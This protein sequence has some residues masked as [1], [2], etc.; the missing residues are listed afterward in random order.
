VLNY[1]ATAFEELVKP[2]SH[3]KV[4]LLLE[5]TDPAQCDQMD[6]YH[7]ILKGIGVGDGSGLM[8][9]LMDQGFLKFETGLSEE[10]KRVAGAVVDYFRQK[11]L[12][13]VIQAY[14]FVDSE[15]VEHSSDGTISAHD[16]MAEIG[17]SVQ[18]VTPAGNFMQ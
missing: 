15:L 1:Q 7:A 10:S 8:E 13:D 14:L 16:V 11:M 17:C 12:K 3:G 9:D 2:L 4:L 5:V 18:A 6:Y